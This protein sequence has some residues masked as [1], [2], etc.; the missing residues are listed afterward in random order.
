MQ[1]LADYWWILLILLVGII[2]NGI[3]ALQRL[4]YKRYLSNKPD[5]PPHRD[6]NAK[7]DDD[8]DQ[9]RKKP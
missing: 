9:P 2:L 1:W 4:D 5:L 8:D 6:N 3:K 7:W